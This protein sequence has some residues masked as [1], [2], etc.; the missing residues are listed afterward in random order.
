MCKCLLNLVPPKDRNF[1][2]EKKKKKAEIDWCIKAYLSSKPLSS[3]SS[4]VE[5]SALSSSFESV[6]ADLKKIDGKLHA[7]NSNAE[8]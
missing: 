5:D 1:M 7:C 6:I 8:F 2:V 3:G 4:S